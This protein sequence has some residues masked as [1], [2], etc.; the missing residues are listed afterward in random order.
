LSANPVTSHHCSGGRGEARMARFSRQ[1]I[2]I[3]AFGRKKAFKTA[4]TKP[5]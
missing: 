3:A 5:H 1:R 4:T 2:G